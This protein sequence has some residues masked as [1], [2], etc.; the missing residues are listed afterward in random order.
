MVGRFLS[1]SLKLFALIFIILAI[2]YFGTCIYGNFLQPGLQ[3]DP[4]AAPEARYQVIINNTG[5]SFFT[6]NV[7]EEDGKYTLSGYYEVEGKRYRYR[8]NILTIDTEYFGPVTVR[9]RR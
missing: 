7:K 1:N 2:G 6:D 4:I 8:E 3:G 5:N 9:I